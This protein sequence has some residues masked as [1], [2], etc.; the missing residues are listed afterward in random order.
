MSLLLSD[1][2]VS[3]FHECFFYSELNIIINYT[4]FSS[5]EKKCTETSF[6]IHR[7]VNTNQFNPALIRHWVNFSC[8]TSPGHFLALECL[9][10]SLPLTLP[11]H[12]N[13]VKSACK[14]TCKFFSMPVFYFLHDN[15]D[16]DCGYPWFYCMSSLI[17]FLHVKG[18]H[19]YNIC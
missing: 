12:P 19:V 4:N 3:L 2:D 9:P 14:F 10:Q 13:P 5:K 7:N 1:W 11:E 15:H 8:S 18:S 17:I 16:H 6:I